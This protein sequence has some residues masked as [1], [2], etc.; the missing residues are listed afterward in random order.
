MLQSIAFG[1]QAPEALLTVRADWSRRRTLLDGDTARPGSQIGQ[2]LCH[3]VE[4]GIGEASAGSR[5]TA[6]T[7]DHPRPRAPGNASAAGLQGFD[8][9]DILAAGQM[10][11]ATRGA[12]GRRTDAEVGAMDVPMIVRVG[13]RLPKVPAKQF[14]MGAMI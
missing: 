5:H 2:A 6:C 14:S 13:V 10:L 12:V 9:R 11:E 4:Q 8:E 3:S 1:D 7:R